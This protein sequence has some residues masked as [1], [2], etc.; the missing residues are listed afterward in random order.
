MRE[1]IVKSKRRIQELETE[2][3]AFQL[4]EINADMKTEKRN[5]I[6]TPPDRTKP[7]R[8]IFPEIP[9]LRTNGN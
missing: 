6:P 9:K 1:T 7:G 8:T 4:A 2:L 3:A 5:L